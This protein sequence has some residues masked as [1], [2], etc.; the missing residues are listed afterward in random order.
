MKKNRLYTFNIVLVGIGILTIISSL[1]LKLFYGKDLLSIPFNTWIWIHIVIC[2]VSL[3]AI[4]YHLYLHWG[5]IKNWANRIKKLHAKINI[6]LVYVS[7]L[8]FLSGIAGL[9]SFL[10]GAS[11]NFIGG[12]HGKLG[13]IFVI[14]LT[15]HTLKRLKWFKNRKE[16]KA[17][18]PTIN[19][20]KCVKCKKCVNQCPADIFVFENEK[21][22][23]KYEDFCLQ[24]K[25][26][27]K[28]CPK[29]A[30]S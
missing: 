22:I 25:K 21:V 9:I 29:N 23:V 7:A 3:F 4:I 30:I 15:L 28:I 19:E 24:C 14:L 18:V 6:S 20:N 2:I 12:I 1:L 11:H 17:F 13:I 16:G 26:C 8:T 27:V 10:S 5:G